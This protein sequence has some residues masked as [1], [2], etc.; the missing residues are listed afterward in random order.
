M[1]S[2]GAGLLPAYFTIDKY[3]SLCDVIGVFLSEIREDGNEP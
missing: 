1:P 3:F 2:P